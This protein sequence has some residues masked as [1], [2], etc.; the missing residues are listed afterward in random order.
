MEKFLLRLDLGKTCLLGS[1]STVQLVPA[2]TLPHHWAKREP[3]VLTVQQLWVGPY[4]GSSN[5]GRDVPFE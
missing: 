4:G 5:E 1:S 2:P 3:L